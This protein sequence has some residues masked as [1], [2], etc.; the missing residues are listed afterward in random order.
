MTRK[1]KQPKPDW[2]DGQTIVPM[3]VEGMPWYHPEQP[4]SGAFAPKEKAPGKARSRDDYIIEVSLDEN[5]KE[6][7]TPIY[8]GVWYSLP[9]AQKQKALQWLIPRAGIVLLLWGLYLGLDFPGT[10]VLYVFLPLACAIFPLAY[11]IMGLVS[12]FR[13]PEKM[14]SLQKEK[15]LG[16][17]T[18]STAAAMVCTG[19]SLIGDI[20][21][22]LQKGIM[23]QEGKGALLLL[24]AV[25]ISGTAFRY[26][27][28]LNTK[29]TE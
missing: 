22:S 5:G 14:S 2:D 12:L 1:H 9:K 15:S 6:I 18:H 27:S 7:R 28:K 13:T 25:L 4:S 19:I 16:R 21:Y 24:L 3:N 11:W 20:V 10:R 23:N 8:R 29:S 17:I 26:V